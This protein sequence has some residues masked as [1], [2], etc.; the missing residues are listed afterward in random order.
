MER[1]NG[2]QQDK[3]KGGLKGKRKMGEGGG[4]KRD[5]GRK[6]KILLLCISS[7]NVACSYTR[8]GKG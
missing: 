3:R 7:H 2:R 8:Q 6:R 1:R 5:E 4:R